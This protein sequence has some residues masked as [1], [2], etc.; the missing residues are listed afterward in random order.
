MTNPLLG[1][2]KIDHICIVVNNLDEAKKAYAEF[3]GTEE[4][5]TLFLPDAEVTK[6]VYYGKDAPQ[7]DGT[8]AI[9]N[10]GNLRIEL[11]QPNAEDSV[12]RDFIKRRGEGLHHIGMNVSGVVDDIEESIAVCEDAGWPLIQKGFY[13]DTEG[14]ATGAYAYIDAAASLKCCL[15][16]LCDFK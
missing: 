15:E 12:W 2:A 9:L 10:L 7:I 11:L 16:L 13:G 5:D 14:K 1:T 8:L 6:T 4:P 3:F